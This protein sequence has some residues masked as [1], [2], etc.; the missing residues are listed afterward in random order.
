MCRLSV[1][2]EWRHGTV[3]RL[4]RRVGRPDYCLALK[5]NQPA[6]YDEV[7][8]WLDDPA[9]L[10][11]DACPSVD[12]DHGR[13]ETRRAIVAHDV[14]WLAERHALPGIAAVARVTATRDG[15]GRT[16]TATRT[17]LLSTKLAAARVA[18]VVRSHWHIENRLHWVLDVVM[19]EDG[20]R[21][22]KDHGPEKLARPRRFA[23]NLPR[24]N[25]DKGSTRGKI[26]RAG[27]DDAPS[28]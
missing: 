9:N 19:G 4:F 8:L 11:D 13:I 20:A 2:G 12:G 17:Y 24:A 14:A 28:C 1:L 7:R 16:T 15:D 5:A 18:Q 3:S 25:P 6:L 26:Q 21:T 27:W 10:P 22:R 23:L